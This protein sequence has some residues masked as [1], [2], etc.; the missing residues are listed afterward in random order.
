M[1]DEGGWLIE[2]RVNR[3]AGMV[4]VLGRFEPAG[5]RSDRVEAV[6]W[7]ACGGPR[8]EIE[9]LL[10][11]AHV[12]DLVTERSGVWRRSKEGRRVATQDAAS[13][14]RVLAMVLLRSGLL[15]SQAIKLGNAGSF[16]QDGSLVCDRRQALALAPQLVGLLRRWPTVELAQALRVPGDLVAE[17]TSLWALRPPRRYDTGQEARLAVGERAEL[18]SFN[19][20]RE[21]LGPEA[22]I[23]WV[24]RE[25]D[26]AGYDIEDRSVEPA[27]RIEVKGHAGSGTRFYLS[28]NEWAVAHDSPSQYEIHYWGEIDLGRSEIEEYG[29]LVARGYPMVFRGLR[30]SIGMGDLWASPDTWIVSSAGRGAAD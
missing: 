17:I 24:S 4:R 2:Q 13:D 15:A 3:L 1:R 30:R 19:R 16:D 28:S 21:E 8:S 22:S 25:D 5:L 12:C 29:D 20:L 10:H 9:R 11:V 18:Y 27:R 14:G 7:E 26:S 6:L 23:V